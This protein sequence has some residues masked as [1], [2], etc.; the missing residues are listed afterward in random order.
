M[1][2]GKVLFIP[3]SFLFI[4][5]FKQHPPADPV[6]QSIR[7]QFEKAERL[8]N[9]T[10]A[11]PLT[12]ST[13]LATF[14]EVIT[15]LN[16]LPKSRFSDS[17]LYLSYS[18]TGILS[19]VYNNFP[20]AIASYLEA[21][22]FSGNPE[23]KFKMYIYAGAVYYKLN[24][25]DSASF[26]LLQAERNIDRVGVP[27]DQVRLYNSLGVLY[28]D[29]G[30]YLQSK[31]YFTRAL[32]LVD[33]E[34][35]A[36]PLITYSLRLNTATC[37]YK[38]G[39]FEQA[40]NIYRDCL[41]YQK[42]KDPLYMNM[43]RA[44]AGLHQYREA[45][46]YFK[47]VKIISVPGVLNEMARTSLESGNADS[48]SLWLIQY[49]NE[50]T[51]LHTNALD[52]GVN[53]LYSADLALYQSDPIPAL[54]HLQDAL[55][56]FSKNFT[57]RN[58]REN[59]ENF[60]GSFAYYRLFEV[61]SKKA[62]AWEM[63]YHK[64][65]RPEDLHSAYDAYASA[66]SLLSYIERSYETDDAK[67]LLKQNSGQLYMDALTVCLKLDLL[68]PGAHWMETAFL[69][70]EKNKAS[71]MSAQIRQS[72]FLHS[73]GRENEWAARERNIKFNI[74][75]LSSRTED[76]LNSEALQKI[77][78]EKSVYESQL[79]KLQREM[80]GDNRF[81]Q[82][83]YADDFPSIS[84]LQKSMS[85]DEA[86]ISFCNTPE[87]IEIFVL[88]RS[89]LRH[90]EL[91]NGNSI[92]N[93]VQDWVR[94]LQTPETG[95]KTQIRYTKDE[96]YRQFVKPLNLLAGDQENWIIVP[97]GLFFQL[98][99]ESL[100]C[101]E[102]GGLILENHTVSY[103]FSARFITVEDRIPD[104]PRGMNSLISFAPFT[105]KGADLQAEGMDWLNQLPFSGEE[106]TSMIG[107]QLT[108]RQ[109]TKEV[110]LKSQNQYPIVHL[111]TH[112]IT[113]PDNPS[114]SCIAFYPASGGSTGD[115]LFLDEIYALRMD[116]CRLMVISA[117][118][119]G[120]G[121]L[122]RNEGV[123]SFARAFLYA[124]CPSTINTLWKADDHTTSEIL[125]LFY[126]YL[127]EGYSKAKALQKAKLEFIRNNPI[128]RNPAYWSHLILTGS[129]ASLFK[130]KQPLF[131]WAVFLIPCVSI[132]YAIVWRRKKSRRFS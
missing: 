34:E 113:N 73:T 85:S 112:A 91:E 64:G 59:P 104:I 122:V 41:N 52:D 60:A 15:M 26:F 98:P 115:L 88:T 25:F 10:N 68:Y 86:L 117:C 18:R 57:S 83:K 51:H 81:Y 7:Q 72:N 46:M 22:D 99:V 131:W 78:D 35:H 53:A 11:T 3:L 6:H 55:I 92:R 16:G 129:Q 23:Q 5:S 87:R 54:S 36:D 20:A 132:L 4:V 130:K 77:N 74:A 42:V 50:K 44:Y 97:D 121:A 33:R 61:F 30:N 71:V 79:V 9:L 40:L 56:I 103:E 126:Q 93:L 84:Q 108:D 58:I 19:E 43:G 114:A 49:Q 119:T 101:D 70:S 69:I 1:S 96:L 17:L 27:E 123:M 80:E 13:C 105:K 29:N 37:F 38:L 107:R 66:I 28:Y 14:K 118:E 109:A 67:L 120:K 39:L 2:S 63:V 128:D 76:R 116:S 48:A 65:G 21:V 110:F 124:G 127:E 95:K 12:D 75:R 47:K 102:K 32:R 62:K 111:A 90:T 82:F 8:Y 106:T 24:N 125:R 45:L 94:I 31:N 100:T 89:G